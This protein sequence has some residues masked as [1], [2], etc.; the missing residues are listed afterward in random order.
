MKFFIRS[1]FA[2]QCLCLVR[3]GFSD[4]STCKD[5]SQEVSLGDSVG[6]I[7][8]ESRSRSTCNRNALLQVSYSSEKIQAAPLWQNREFHLVAHHKTGTVMTHEAAEKMLRAAFEEESQDAVAAAL[9]EGVVLEDVIE[10]SYSDD[11]EQIVNASALPVPWI[12]ASMHGMGMAT[13]TSM[14][15]ISDTP[16]CI[17]H[18]SR[19]PFEVLV[20]GYIYHKASLE[21]W[22]GLSFVDADTD[23][24]W[25][26]L[27]PI[28]QASYPAEQLSCFR[29]YCKN[30]AE[31]WHGS[32][33][34]PLSSA[35]PDASPDE[36]Y[37]S[38]L[39]RIDSAAGLTAE[40][41]WAFNSTLAP[42][43]FVNDFAKSSPCSTSTCLSDFYDDCESTWKRILHAWEIPEP[44]FSTLLR[45]AMKSCPKKSSMAQQHSS[46]NAAIEAEVAHDQE[47][48]LVAMAR[49]LD[50]QLFG[51]RL[52]ELEA[53][54]GCPVSGKYK[55]P[56]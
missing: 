41:A 29:T 32:L 25:Q 10:A 56:Q 20:S 17:A 3:C 55:A 37:S 45:G 13:D 27:A 18:I 46:A 53:H 30:M 8:R 36:S 38:Y 54:L 48:D 11:L 6:A 24:N 34:G 52:A 28:R 35:L 40:A 39:N 26:Y 50:Q 4:T 19:N 9:P 33:R 51:G 2:L 12:E 21:A 49:K 47:H 14:L 1:A 42:M 44:Q 43:E 16:K 23:C 15:K 7:S 31:I 22:L 5:G